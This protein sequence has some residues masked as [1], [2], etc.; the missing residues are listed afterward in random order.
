[1]R[2]AVAKFV[3]DEWLW[4]DLGGENG[5]ARQKESLCLLLTLCRKCDRIVVPLGTPFVQKFWALS[6]RA[7]PGD[8]LR[9]VVKLFRQRFL[10]NSEKSLQLSLEP[11]GEPPIE[12]DPEDRYL[13]QALLV[14]SA[15]ALVT[16]DGRLIELVR[17]RHRPALHRD[18][19]L[20][21]YLES[22]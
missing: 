15:D 21:E 22:S 11:L 4:A 14:S 19:F 17:S 10:E 8:P 18:E 16:T 20:A 9:A 1:M 13:V 2:R 7:S 5:P 3:L 6:E 12:V